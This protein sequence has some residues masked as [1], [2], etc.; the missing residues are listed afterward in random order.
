M[1]KIFQR[2][3]QNLDNG[4]DIIYLLSNKIFSKLKMGNFDLFFSLL[5]KENIFRLQQFLIIKNLTLNHGKIINKLKTFKI[6]KNDL[7]K[8]SVEDDYKFFS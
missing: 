7:S 6:I 5:I 2:S 3:F 8:V 4:G 1:D